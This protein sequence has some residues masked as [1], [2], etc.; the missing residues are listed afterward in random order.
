MKELVFSFL[1]PLFFFFLT[2]TIQSPQLL[3]KSSGN[4]FIISSNFLAPRMIFTSDFKNTI[5]HFISLNKKFKYVGSKKFN[6]KSRR[7]FDS[8]ND[9]KNIPLIFLTSSIHIIKS[10][11]IILFHILANLYLY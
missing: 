2:K 1:L 9:K 7:F 6:N 4:S 10:Y 11:D 8:Q 5:C 3:L